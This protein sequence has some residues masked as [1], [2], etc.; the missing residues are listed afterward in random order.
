[1]LVLASASPRRRELLSRLGVP[2]EVV[3]S[4]ADESAP[5]GVPPDEVAR[6]VARRKAESV[7]RTRDDAVLGADTIVVA[8]D[9]EILGKPADAADARR[10]LRK[11]SGTTHRVVTGVC[12]A[13]E[14]GTRFETGSDST[15]VTM[16]PLTDAEIE[17]YVAS[18]E[19]YD[20]AGAYAIQETGDRF[21]VSVDGSFTNV[22][23]LPLELVGTMLA[24]AGIGR[25]AWA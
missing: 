18:G 17:A 9:G 21:V 3:T 19:S 7:A 22:V 24:A 23:G 6:L 8:S 10:I 16:R 2:F 1:M 5:A 25:R 13:T 15:S 20:K 4:G 14:R 11:L 12:L